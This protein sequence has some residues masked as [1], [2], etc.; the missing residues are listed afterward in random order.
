ME[1]ITFDKYELYG[2]YHWKEYEADTEYRQ[3]VQKVLSWVEERNV[4]D[5]GAGDGLITKL[6]GAKGLDNSKRGVDLAIEHGADVALGTAYS[7][8]GQYEAVFMGDVLEHLEF[9]EQALA[10]A[11]KVAPV[12]YL[13]TPKKSEYL[14]GYHYQ[15]WTPSELEEFLTGNGYRL[16]GVMETHK[17]RVYGR[18]IRL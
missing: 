4:L 9:P 10:E 2:P 14:S 18:F 5:V 11:R 6:L 1:K 12:L 8:N 16:D 13:V 3:H 15:E 17:S 7:L